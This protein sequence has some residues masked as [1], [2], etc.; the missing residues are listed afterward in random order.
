MLKRL[1]AAVAL[2]IGLTWGAAAHAQYPSTSTRN[3]FG[4]YNYSNGGYSNPNI[5]GGYN[6]DSPSGG[7]TYS[8]RN[9]FGGYNYSNGWYSTPNVFGGYNYYRR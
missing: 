9:V 7:M 6:H 8:T 5:F 3:I 1:L 4:G 2:L